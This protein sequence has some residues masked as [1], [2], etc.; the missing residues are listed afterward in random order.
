M[1]PTQ[2]NQK[3]TSICVLFLVA[4]FSTKAVAQLIRAVRSAEREDG[5]YR[6]PGARIR[7]G[8]AQHAERARD[9][10][11]LV[12]EFRRLEN[13]VD[14]QRQVSKAPVRC[15]TR[16]T[17]LRCVISQLASRLMPGSDAADVLTSTSVFVAVSMMN[18]TTAAAAASATHADA[19]RGSGRSLYG[20][21]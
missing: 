14:D 13:V 8:R 7:R 5:R 10:E 16:S 11:R 17:T 19:S 9:V 21:R 3:I 15:S 1:I 2:K 20:S 12:N 6:R 18:T 4:L